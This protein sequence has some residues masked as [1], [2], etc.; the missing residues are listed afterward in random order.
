MNKCEQFAQFHTGSPLAPRGDLSHE[1]LT[2]FDFWAYAPR[3]RF[4]DRRDRHRCD[5]EG[6]KKLMRDRSCL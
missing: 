3:S 6:G 5:T 4:V 2:C 1:E